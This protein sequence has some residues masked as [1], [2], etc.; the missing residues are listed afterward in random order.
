[1]ISLNAC[2]P[3]AA[4]LNNWRSLQGLEVG[5]E[6]LNLHFLFTILGC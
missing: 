2:A 4:A 6:G 3:R 1:M 5:I